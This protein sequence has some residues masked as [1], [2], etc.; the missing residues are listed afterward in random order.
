MAVGKA[1]ERRSPST[2]SERPAGIT[3]YLLASGKIEIE[4]CMANHESSRTTSLYDRQPDIV[5]LDEIELIRI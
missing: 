2:P 3:E 5:A 4:Q 1:C